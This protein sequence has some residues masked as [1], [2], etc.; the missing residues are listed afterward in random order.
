MPDK[1]RDKAWIP[2][3]LL[4]PMRDVM[5]GRAPWPLVLIGPAG[6]GKTCAALCLSDH[7]YGPRRYTT[8]DELPHDCIAAGNGELWEAGERIT[9]PRLRERWKRAELA[10]LDEVGLRSEV[11][12]W[13]FVCSKSWIDYREGRPLVV[14]ANRTLAEIERIYDDRFA[15]RLA[16][17]TVVHYD[18]KDRRVSK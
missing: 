8:A 3:E 14:I 6:V 16:G 10:I 5:Y 18:G 2:D 17:G 9:V 15:S 13:H 4:G 12:D 1:A 7:T 11:S